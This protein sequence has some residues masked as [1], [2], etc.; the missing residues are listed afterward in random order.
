MQKVLNEVAKRLTSENPDSDELLAMIAE[1]KTI[2]TEVGRNEWRTC[3]KHV[4]AAY[5]LKMPECLK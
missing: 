3:L 1:L 4:A 5:G 2:E